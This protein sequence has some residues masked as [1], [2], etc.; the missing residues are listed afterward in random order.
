MRRRKT[1][2]VGAGIAAVVLAGWTGGCSNDDDNK[3]AT[4]TDTV[5]AGPKCTAGAKECLTPKVARVCPADGSGWLSQ[6]CGTG[7]VCDQ[8]ECKL[9]PQGAC[10]PGSAVCVNQTTALRCK[11]DLKGF[12]Q[13]PCPP[14]TT[15]ANGLCVGSCIVGS[16]KCLDNGTVGTCTDGKT[17]APTACASGQLCVKTTDLPFSQAACKTAEC[18]PSPAGCDSVCGDRTNP[19]AD[20]TKSTSTCVATPNGY[21]WQ[22]TTCAAGVSC[23]PASAHCAGGSMQASCKTECVPGTSRCSGAGVQAC[24]DDGKW[25]A[26]TACATD[27]GEVCFTNPNDTRKAVCGHPV[28]ALVPAIAFAMQNQVAITGACTQSGQIQRCDANGKLAAAAACPTGACVA[29][30]GLVAGLQPGACQAACKDGDERCTGNGASTYQTCVNG[31]WSTATACASADGGPGLC[32]DDQ[33]ATGRPTKVCGDCRPGSQRCTAND[34]D[35]GGD[36]AIE[37]CSATGTWGA[38]TACLLGT[39]QPSGSKASCV[40]ECLPGKTVCTGTQKGVAGTPYVGTDSFGVCTAEGKLPTT[41]LTT[42]TGSALCRTVH[43]EAVVVG[44]SACL[45]CIGSAIAGGN[46]DGL[47]DTRCSNA[48]GDAGT[49]TE[50]QTCGATNTWGGVTSC[51]NNGKSCQQGTHG[52]AN[53]LDVCQTRSGHLKT[54]TYYQSPVGKHYGTPGT[55]VMHGSRAKNDGP[56]TVCGLT[57]DC[58]SN[59]CTRATPATLAH[60]Q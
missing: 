14:D 22:V 2:W 59:D 16:T 32:F 29:Q 54:E 28:C 25:G 18:F 37:T 60:C 49:G 47:V 4:T 11:A 42:C 17:Y 33:S 5:E 53:K 1:A 8:G 44:A 50:L 21:K 57:P 27:P 45:D 26:T 23:A 3:G 9:D 51:T 31:Q 35:A 56:P 34:G 52:S 43:A 41:G 40:T 24:G 39:C 46:E 48:A 30:G 58:C 55:C 19:S 13:V 7:E 20:Q 6:T 36:S 12:E 38:P 15:C 10:F